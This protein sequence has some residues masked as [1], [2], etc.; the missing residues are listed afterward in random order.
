MRRR[1]G[2]HFYVFFAILLKNEISIRLLPDRF[3]Y[4]LCDELGFYVMD[5]CDV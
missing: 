2:L 5:E 3:F 1:R 4:E